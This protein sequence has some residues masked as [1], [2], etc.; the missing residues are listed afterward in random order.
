MLDAIVG[1]ALAR[2]RAHLVL[3]TGGAGVGKSR[4]VSEVA[5]RARRE[6]DAEVLT[7]RC[8]PYG[9]D[10]WWPIAET[11]RAVCS[12][13][14]GVSHDEA[15]TIVYE[16]VAKAFDRGVEDPEVARVG[17]GLLY[18]L[19]YDEELHD[20]DPARARGDA[21][22]SGQALFRYVAEHRPVVLVLSDLHWADGVVL[23]LVDRL[24]G[25]LRATPFVLLATA[26]PEL[27]E[28]WR[29]E[30]GRH[31]LSVL[32]LEPL[33]ALA[34][35]ALVEE[36]LG[37]D[38]SEE[39]TAVLRERSG[40][41]PFFIEELAA[42]IRESGGGTGRLP[43]TLQGLVTARLD[44]LTAAERDL[45]E[46]CAVVGASGPLDAVVT[47]A[48]AREEAEPTAV[49][50]TLTDRELLELDDG[51]FR[52]PSEV[53]RDVAYG[54]LTKAERARRHA[55]LAE[56]LSK[57]LREDEAGT[58]ATER[59]AHH[60][61]AAALLLRELGT[62]D[63]VPSDLPERALAMLELAGDRAW[64][65][66]LWPSAS[67]LFEQAL[68]VL[69]ASTPDETRWRL[70]LGHITAATAQHHLAVARAEVDAVLMD[71]PD[72]RTAA[73]ALTLLGEVHQ[74]AGDTTAAVETAQ[75]AIDAW[76]ALDD[77][78]GVASALRVRGVTYMFIGDQDAADQDLSAALQAFEAAGD[79]RGEAWALQNLASI[80]F[81]RGD[82]ERADDRV[83]RSVAVFTELGDYG[84][85]NWCRSI[86]AWVR[87]MQGRQAEAEALAHEQ[88]AET[89]AT[90]NR[91]LAAILTLLLANLQLWRGES[92]RAIAFGRDALERFEATSDPWGQMQARASLVRSLACRGRVGDALDLLE[93]D[94]DPHSP[95]YD[96]LVRAQLLIH[97]GD[98]DALPAALHVGF[99]EGAGPEMIATGRLALGLALLQAG[100]V[101]EAVAELEAARA[102]GI[103]AH[104]GSS[105]AVTAGLSLAYAT[106]GRLDEA[107]SLADGG[108]VE[109]TYLDQ[110]QLGLG[111]A[112]ARLRAG[113]PEAAAA[114]DDVV[115]DS[116]ATEARLDQ[117]ITRLARA[118]AWRALAHPEAE[119]A[120][121]D[122][123][124][125]LDV[126]GIAAPG[127][128]RAFELASGA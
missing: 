24:L 84:G 112:F 16:D 123:R 62:V 3:I 36:L 59:V 48:E 118:Y 108:D 53:V 77:D 60:Y 80:A 96:V 103:A 82:A 113:D 38:A 102:V 29:P 97:L 89:A 126:L 125:R 73:R 6:H 115:A 116:D 117:A 56:W 44:S 1:S 54:T 58:S 25:A 57:G 26:R 67:R 94:G 28:R 41:N 85:L 106:A 37:A 43:A 124:S 12:V 127:W 101:T 65:A 10:V 2:R 9:E 100:R 21:L 30:T 95:T 88:L 5:A 72:P 109:G 33:D 64:A 42:L 46:D 19:G 83:E 66:E 63:G 18:L 128:S 71:D 122:A 92:E 105:V 32:N 75:D 45:L 104:K 74:R 20:V 52:F 110:L 49:L 79:R 98:R 114:F 121:A 69:P 99:P 15:R 27:E 14:H 86:Q 81:F 90:G 119:P 7:G 13:P 23:D 76:R 93:G 17:R 50:R 68:A 91:W 40:G 35:D 70:Q 120:M 51:E 8:V 34:S 31:N 55:V 47:L 78:L 111:R 87:F 61:G 39:L 22:R 107:R 11:I 4:L